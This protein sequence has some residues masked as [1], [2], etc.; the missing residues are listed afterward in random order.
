MEVQGRDVAVQPVDVLGRV[1]YV[2][3]VIHRKS[4]ICSTCDS[5]DTDSGS[6][7]EN[8]EKKSKYI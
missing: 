4:S 8:K 3:L 7:L 2:V 5:W 6:D 1:V